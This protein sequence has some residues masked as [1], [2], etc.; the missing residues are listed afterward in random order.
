MLINY[1]IFAAPLDDS[2]KN[3]NNKQVSCFPRKAAILVVK[4]NWLTAIEL[5]QIFSAV[6]S[7]KHGYLI[8]V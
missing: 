3:A 8:L 5:Y 2:I 4:N 6:T 7:L 1:P